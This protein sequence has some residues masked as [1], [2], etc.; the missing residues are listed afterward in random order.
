[1]PANAR[2]RSSGFVAW[3]DFFFSLFRGAPR[4]AV[5]NVPPIATLSYKHRSGGET[6]V[7]GEEVREFVESRQPVYKPRRISEARAKTETKVCAHG[8]QIPVVSMPTQILKKLFRMR[9]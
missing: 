7:E 1:M 5:R 6:A 4:R 3:G 8:L 2:L 9:A